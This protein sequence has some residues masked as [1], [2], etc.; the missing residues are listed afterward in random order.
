MK[1]IFSKIDVTAKEFIVGQTKAN[2]MEHFTLT[3]RKDMGHLLFQM[4]QSLRSIVFFE[5]M[6]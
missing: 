6:L 2:I 5:F 3:K 4:E 1:G